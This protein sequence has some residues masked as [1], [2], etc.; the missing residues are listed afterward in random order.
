MSK[1]SIQGVRRSLITF[2]AP[3]PSGPYVSE[4]YDA[5]PYS[6]LHW[7]SSRLRRYRMSQHEGCRRQGGGSNLTALDGSA[8]GLQ[9]GNGLTCTATKTTTQA[10]QFWNRE[11]ALH[12]TGL[13]AR[14]FNIG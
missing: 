9:A 2:A 7:Q 14:I 1:I 13:S 4:H 8:Q 3:G 10:G 12:F 6:G 5:H 11:H